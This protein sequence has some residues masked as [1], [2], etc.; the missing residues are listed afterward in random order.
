M[1]E[2]FN[3]DDEQRKS[4]LKFL[5]GDKSKISESE[6]YQIK[7]YL[8]K[9]ENA[10]SS[11]IDEALQIK[12]IESKIFTI[13]ESIEA[14]KKD[15]PNTPGPPGP[16][17]KQGIDGP[18]GP[19]GPPGPEGSPG[20]DG[21]P[22]PMGPKGN[23]GKS[24][25]KADIIKDLRDDYEFI[26]QIKSD[27]GPSWWAM[28]GGGENNQGVNVGSGV[29]I[30]KDKENVDLQFKSLSG[31]NIIVEET[32]EI[33]NFSGVKSV[34]ITPFESI[35]A[36]QIE[37]GTIAFAVPFEINNYVLTAAV[38][39]VHDA[40]TGTG[41]TDIQI[42]RRRSGSD[43]DILTTPITLSV[44]EYYAID[45]VINTDNNTVQTGDQIFIDVDS[46]TTTPPN[47]LAVTLTFR[48]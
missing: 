30:Y 24:I 17:G 35:S 34:C 29:G 36:V 5:Q 48:K 38:A 7:D 6:K 12:E 27:A 33:I 46:V 14:L 8:A 23:P 15:V 41:S 39:T 42:R 19:P 40:G 2:K 44:G 3:L 37:T 22:G 28:G 16:E 25:K 47:G 9:N 18:P 43:V 10:S 13:I 32:E 45:G 4:I 1:N 31:D 21:K 26:Q 20:R 11:P